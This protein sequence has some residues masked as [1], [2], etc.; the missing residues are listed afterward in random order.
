MESAESFEDYRII[1]V[2]VKNISKI[3][4]T[5]F[6]C[7]SKSLIVGEKLEFVVETNIE[8]EEK[9][10][11]EIIVLYKFYKIYKDGKS[12]CIQDYSTKNDVYYKELEDGSYRILCLVK[13]ILSNKEYDDRAILVYTVKPYKDIKINSFVADLNSPQ[14]SE[15]DIKFTSEVARWK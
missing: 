9:E 4:I 15:T 3:E 12:V 2:N 8:A 5:N 11:D 7:L 1:K 10:K 13:S 6:K 14:A